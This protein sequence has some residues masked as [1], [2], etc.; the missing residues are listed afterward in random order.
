VRE[1]NDNT[2]RG[3]SWDFELTETEASLSNAT[4]TDWICRIRAGQENND[5]PQRQ[6]KFVFIDGFKTKDPQPRSLT[7]RTFLIRRKDP[8]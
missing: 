1:D 4:E 2:K 7:L 8:C 6:H 5:L 3:E